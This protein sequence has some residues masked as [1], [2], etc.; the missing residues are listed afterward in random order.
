MNLFGEFICYSVVVVT[1]TVYLLK[2]I[3]SHLLVI[4]IYLYEIHLIV[5]P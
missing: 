2:L 5:I 4:S 3:N 1:K